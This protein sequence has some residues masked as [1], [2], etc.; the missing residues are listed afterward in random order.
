MLKKVSLLKKATQKKLLKKVNSLKK[1]LKKLLKK[2]P[3]KLPFFIYF[4]PP[5]GPP[6]P[7]YSRIGRGRQLQGAN[8]SR[9]LGTAE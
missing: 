6:F 7:Q 3:K 8:N 9:D 1:V 4:P 5:R 2:V